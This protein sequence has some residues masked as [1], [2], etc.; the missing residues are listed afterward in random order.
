MQT[1]VCGLG[2]PHSQDGRGE[3]NAGTMIVMHGVNMIPLYYVRCSEKC[4]I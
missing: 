3:H 2:K 4:T 1:K